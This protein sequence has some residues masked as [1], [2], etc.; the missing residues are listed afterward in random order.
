MRNFR[1]CGLFEPLRII[2]QGDSVPPY[3]EV[4]REHRDESRVLVAGHEPL[5]GYLAAHLLGA[6]SLLID[7][8]KGAIVR[9]DVDH[10]TDAQRWVNLLKIISE[11]IRW[12]NNFYSCRAEGD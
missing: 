3:E 6:P 10:F 9:I 2:F 1:I 5:F 12:G 4:I 8:K 7:F 11:S